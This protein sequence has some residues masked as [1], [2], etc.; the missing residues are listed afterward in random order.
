MNCVNC[1]AYLLNVY[2]VYRLMFIFVTLVVSLVGIGT[3]LHKMGGN[4][5]YLGGG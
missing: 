3:F 2:I 4:V 1:F 5:V